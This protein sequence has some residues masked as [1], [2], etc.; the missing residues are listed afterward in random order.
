MKRN[1]PFI[2]EWIAALRSGLF[3][4]TSGKLR[5]LDNKYCCLGVAC[6]L[7]DNSKWTTME[8]EYHWN[9]EYNLWP[10]DFQDE[11][12]L[13]GDEVRE[14]WHRNDTRLHNFNQIADYL[15]TLIK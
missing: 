12:G 14:L 10:Q 4:Q 13:T 6:A 8:K 3:E 9:R 7:K 1:V 15:E 5:S 11:V 2:K